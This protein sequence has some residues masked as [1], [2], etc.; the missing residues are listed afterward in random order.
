MRPGPKPG[1]R[2]D[3]LPAPRTG[4]E[5][6]HDQ[7][8]VIVRLGGRIHQE[9][10]HVHAVECFLGLLVEELAEFVARVMYAGRVHEDKLRGLR[11]EDAE[12]AAARGLRPRRDG[13]DLL[14]EQGV[15]QRGL[16]HVGFAE[17]GDKAGAEVSHW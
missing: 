4:A 7:A 5:Q 15:D 12:L 2:L 16:A 11:G 9:E 3:A 6:V 14:A 1:T 8:V 13:G 10:R 17:D